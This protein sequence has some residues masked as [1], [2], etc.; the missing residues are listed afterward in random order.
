MRCV[1]EALGPTI[2]I[3]W[4]RFLAPSLAR[5]NRGPWAESREATQRAAGPSSRGSGESRPCLPVRLSRLVCSKSR[6]LRDFNIDLASDLPLVGLKVGLTIDI[7][8]AM[9]S[10]TEIRDNEVLGNRVEI[11]SV[12]S[13]AT[14]MCYGAIRAE[15]H[16]LGMA[17]V[18]EW[19]WGFEL[20]RRMKAGNQGATTE[21]CPG[22]YVA[23]VQG[24]MSAPAT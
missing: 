19:D 8:P 9:V 20:F 12:G 16:K 17:L 24:F 5:S 21:G 11:D 18:P 14:L 22:C 13:N 1:T 2:I 23:S 10:K 6:I 4:S 7:I 3:A 15:H